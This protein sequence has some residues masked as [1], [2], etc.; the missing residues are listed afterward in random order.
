MFKLLI[1]DL[2]TLKEQ[3]VGGYLNNFFSGAD[4]VV[5]KHYQKWYTA[6]KIWKNNPEKHQGRT[7]A[8]QL[9]KRFEAFGTM[10]RQ[11]GCSRQRTATTPVNKEAVEEIICF[12]EDHPRNHVTPKYIAK[13]LKISQ[14]SVQRMIKRKG[15]KQ[16][17]RIKT[18][19][20]N[21]A[22]LKILVVYLKYSKQ[23][24]KSLSAQSFNMRVIFRYHHW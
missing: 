17:K 5:M 15:I 11:K 8:K 9:I 12:Q 21:D 23:I 20:M 7:S 3:Q 1:N 6:Y 14:S 19:H 18:P 16:F 10:E 4:K 22:T 24:H 2:L 13:G